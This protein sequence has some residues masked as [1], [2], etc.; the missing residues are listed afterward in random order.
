MKVSVIIPVYNRLQSAHEAVC[1]VLSQTY[2]NF[3]LI[4]INDGS[5]NDLSELKLQVQRAGHVFISQDNKGVSAARNLGVRCSLGR[6]IAFLDSDDIWYPKKL[7]LQIEYMQ[8]NPAIR[9]CQTQEAWFRNGRFVNPKKRHKKPDG[10]AFFCSL[11]LCCI[12][13]SATMME[14]TLFDEVGGFDESL[15]VCEDYDLWLRIAAQ[16]HV[17]LVDEVLIRKNGGH[18]DQLSRSQEAMDRFRLYAMEKTLR[19]V[20]LSVEKRT[21]L[22]SE[23]KRKAEVLMQGSLKRGRKDISLQFLP[24][25]D[26]EPLS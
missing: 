19:T 14:R 21:A 16:Y 10:E 22:L 13:P 26:S 8:K 17:G 20:N 18:S 5:T 25:F 23:M 4:V 1:S 2:K 11:E 24:P 9:I 3:E 12:S 6:Y 15:P 7:E